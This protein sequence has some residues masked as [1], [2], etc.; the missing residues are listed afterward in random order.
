MHLSQPLSIQLTP[1]Q[2]AWIDAHK[3]IGL[4]RSATLRLVV[5]EAMKLHCQGL[6]PHTGYREIQ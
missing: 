3:P 2:L 5:Q 1:E 6:L 4:S